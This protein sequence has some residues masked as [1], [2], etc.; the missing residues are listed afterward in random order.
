[1]NL[2]ELIKKAINPLNIDIVKYPSSDLRRRQ[3]LLKHFNINK[4]L[5]VGANSGQY[6]LGIRKIGFKGNI[7]SFEPVGYVFD[8]LRKIAIKDPKWEVHNIALGD[9]KE[10]L[11]INISQNTFSSSIL[12]M[13]PEH[14][15][16]APEAI[17]LEKETISVDKLDNLF[18][19]LISPNDVV[20]LKLD[21]QGFEKN[22]LEGAKESLKNI[23][24][25]Q[26]EMSVIEMYEGELTY[27]EMID[28]LAK[29]GF[30]LYS[31]E[32]GFFNNE[33]GQLLQV[34]GIFFKNR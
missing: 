23:S 6:A 7:V 29:H 28:Y 16:S 3:K 26:V 27:L 14:L 2:V 19:S 17:Y 9:K 20:L 30:S 4:I 13:M 22:V 21:V 12:N 8:K 15:K 33:T 24:G 1:M 11:E 32:N 34:D 10:N 25:V 31:L 18:S 5:D